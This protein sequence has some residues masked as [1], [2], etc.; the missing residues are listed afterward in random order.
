MTPKYASSGKMSKK[1]EVFSFCV[2]ILELMTG[3]K[4]VDA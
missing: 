2:V 3:R 1:S 4:P